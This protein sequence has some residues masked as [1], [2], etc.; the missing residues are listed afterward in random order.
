[1]SQK[2]SDKQ[3]RFR[4]GA[5]NAQSTEGNGDIVFDDV[6]QCIYVFGKTFYCKD[7]ETAKS[8]WDVE[9]DMV[10]VASWNGGGEAKITIEED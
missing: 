9:P 5:S 10:E 4:F 2:L 1:M 3:V 8:V 7:S 6:N